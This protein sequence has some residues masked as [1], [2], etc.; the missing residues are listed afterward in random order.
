MPLSSS[1]LEVI[2]VR[3]TVNYWFDMDHIR[4]YRG[5][6]DEFGKTRNKD[7]L[8][9]YFD[10]FIFGVD[11]FDDFLERTAGYKRLRQLKEMDGGQPIYTL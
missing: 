1:P 7:G 3:A 5:I 11:T 9:K 2:R 8:K 4:M 6:C 10:E